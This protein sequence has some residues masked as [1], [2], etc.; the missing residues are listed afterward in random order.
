MDSMEIISG[1]EFICLKELNIKFSNLKTRNL[2]LMWMFLIFHA[3]L[4]ELSTLWRCQLMVVLQ[5]TQ[6]TKL[7]RNM[8]LD[9]AMLNVLMI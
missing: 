3:V 5:S 8:V 1:L 7:E 4:T 6:I 9:I 2:L